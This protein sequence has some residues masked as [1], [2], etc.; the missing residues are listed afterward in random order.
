MTYGPRCRTGRRVRQ[1][2]PNLNQPEECVVKR[3]TVIIAVC[4][5]PCINSCEKRE[6]V[7]KEPKVLAKPSFKAAS[8]TVA[9]MESESDP[10]HRGSLVES[11]RKKRLTPLGRI[12]DKPPA[13]MQDMNE[14]QELMNKPG[15]P[16]VDVGLMAFKP[17]EIPSFPFDY[18]NDVDALKR[19]YRDHKLDTII[20]GTMSDLEKMS[21][22]MVH[23]FEFMDGGTPPSPDES[24]PSA[25]G[26][27]RLRRDKGIGGGSEHYAALFCQLALSCGYTARLVSMH[28]LDENGEPLTHDVC[29][30]Y[31]R[32]YGKWVV[33]DAFSDATYYLRDEI[34][35]SALELRKLM[36]DS[37]YRDIMPVSLLGDFTDVL[38]FREKLLPRYRFLYI[39]RMNDILGRSGGHAS[40]PWEALYQAHLVWED[41][42]SPVSEGGFEKLAKFNHP[43]H[44]EYPLDGVRFVTHDEKDFDWKVNSVAVRIERLAEERIRVWMDTITPNFSHFLLHAEVEQNTYEYTVKK[45]YI[46]LDMIYVELFLRPV[47]KLGHGGSVSNIVLTNP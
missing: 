7:N 38:Q 22:L 25:A 35:Q 9:L 18:E 2:N 10:F 23:T 24:V 36:L 26:I 17:L 44:P 21:A 28:T 4:I 19:L 11:A 29:E 31:M 3:L 8:G 42:Y 34:P 1:S 20:D 27:T 15:M 33:F 47:N 40:I 41:E 32:G 12:N 14:A 5:I 6:P 16:Q 46:D 45:N 30:V 37:L 13:F 43:E 39:W